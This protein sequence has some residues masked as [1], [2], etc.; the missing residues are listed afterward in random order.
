[1]HC[2]KCRAKNRHIQNLRKEYDSTVAS[3]KP[4]DQ[5]E[6]K[7]RIVE[8]LKELKNTLGSVPQAMN[9]TKELFER[10]IVKA[11]GFGYQ[12]LDD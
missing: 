1:M 10:Q 7:R 12:S 8:I 2:K 5:I 11:S 3:A 4:A 6:Q 9:E